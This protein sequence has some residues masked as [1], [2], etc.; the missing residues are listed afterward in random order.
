MAQATT[1]IIKIEKA[2]EENFK[3]YGEVL[4][5]LSQP[6]SSS[7]RALSSSWFSGFAIDGTVSISY[8]KYQYEKPP[9]EWVIRR[10]S[11]HRSV[12][13][14]LIPLEGKPC[15]V[16]VAAPTPWGSKPDLEQFRAFLLDGTQGVVMHKLTW[17]N[18]A[19]PAV[20]PLNPPT[21]S[22]ID[23]SDKDAHQEFRSLRSGQD[24]QEYTR[25]FDLEK[26][27][28]TVIQLAW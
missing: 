12:T 22:I 6:P 15:V 4:G 3:P 28:G 26:E 20:F 21:Y 17:H 16:T 19:V 24:P 7:P 11:Q 13:Q 5:P 27:F 18:W 2:T 14:S 8:V 25:V 1:K 10:L 23:I 9:T